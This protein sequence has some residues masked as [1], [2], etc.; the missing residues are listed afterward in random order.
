M[1]LGAPRMPLSEI[2][3]TPLVDV[4]LVLLIIFMVTAPFLQGGL[5]IDLPKI[6]SRGLDV[7]EGLVISVRADRTVAVG[8]SVVPLSDFE[9]ALASAG[10]ARRPVFLK[11]DQRV[12]YGMIVEL[13]SRMRRSGVASLG[14]VTE[15]PPR[16]R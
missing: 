13:I 4:V 8:N 1:K 7:R 12:P 2:N 10:A 15:P 5:E 3:V 14:L 9:S 6:A 16:T 11:A